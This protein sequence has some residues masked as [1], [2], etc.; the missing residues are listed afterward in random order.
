L[1][2]LPPHNPA[3]KTERMP[4]MGKPEFIKITA[5]PRPALFIH[6]PKPKIESSTS[7]PAGGLIAR[8]SR[9]VKRAHVVSFG[10]S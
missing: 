3:N 6:F 2:N 1:P 4:S 10:R 8:G 7:G 5:V 9:L